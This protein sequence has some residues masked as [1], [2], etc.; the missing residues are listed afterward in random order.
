MKKINFLIASLAI[1]GLATLFYSCEEEV[2]TD[3]E[4][5]TI[6]N[7]SSSGCGGSFQACSNGTSIWYTYNGKKYTCASNSNCT[8]AA[9]ALA[10][11]MCGGSGVSKKDFDLKV[12]NVLNS[13]PMISK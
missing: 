8:A 5:G 4:V 2:I 9:T 6:C 3:S 7:T 11:D 1:I 13:V 10:N 12:Q